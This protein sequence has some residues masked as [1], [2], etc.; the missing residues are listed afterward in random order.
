M[1]VYTFKCDNCGNYVELQLPVKDR[2]NEYKCAF[3]DCG[4]LVRYIAPCHFHLKGEC[5]SKDGYIR[6][7]T[8]DS[9]MKDGLRKGEGII[10][11]ETD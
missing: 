6:K 10:K 7:E 8:H 4:I 5:W 1:P 2:D 9:Y 3:C 11:R